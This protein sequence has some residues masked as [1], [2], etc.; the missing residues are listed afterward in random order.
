[1]PF[2]LA[3]SSY[4]GLLVKLGHSLPDPPVCGP[5][6]DDRSAVLAQLEGD[7]VGLE[8]GDSVGHVD[9]VID[10]LRQEL[11]ATLVGVSIS[12]LKRCSF[13]PMTKTDT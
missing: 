2:I 10:V 8:A 12:G 9:V 7:V 6:V 4:D 13:I 5:A 1:M 3:G 11:D